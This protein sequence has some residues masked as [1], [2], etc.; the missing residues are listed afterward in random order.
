MFRYEKRLQYPVKIKSPNPALAKFIISQYGGPDGEL[1][2]SM[3]YLSQR[4]AMPWPELKALLT[5]I[6]TEELGH[7]EMVASIVQQLTRKM[8]DKEVLEAGLETY[9]VDHTAGVYPQFASGTPWTAATIGVKGDVI[10]DLTEDMAAEQKAR[11]T[12]DNILRLSDDPDVNDV[13]RFL[14]E[15]EVVHYQ[16]FGE[17][18]RLATERLD[19][20]NVYMVNPAFD[21]N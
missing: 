19:Q 12:Y 2:A 16:R 15:R 14:R 8:T 4:Y 1:G 13:I 11:T 17:A 3:R 6:G 7:L 5:D 21:R 20:K 18:L 9:F 10:T